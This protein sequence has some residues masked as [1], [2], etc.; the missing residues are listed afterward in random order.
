M[1]VIYRYKE[2]HNMASNLT[3]NSFIGLQPVICQ[4]S[5]E[6]EL[7]QNK[8]HL[9]LNHSTKIKDLMLDL[10]NTQQN[11]IVNYINNSNNFDQKSESHF[12]DQTVKAIT[13]LDKFNSQNVPTINEKISVNDTEH[14]ASLT[15]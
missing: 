15:E 14:Y 1:I 5:E 2:R 8:E 10:P 11:E 13:S 6:N 9:L 12:I 4:S 3:V 7:M